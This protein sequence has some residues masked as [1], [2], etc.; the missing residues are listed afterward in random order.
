MTGI[1]LNADAWAVVV[2]CAVLVV[3]FMATY[4]RSS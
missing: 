2:I 1:H 3:A 4:G